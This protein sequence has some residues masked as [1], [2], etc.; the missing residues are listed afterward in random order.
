MQ[1][2]LPQTNEGTDDLAVAVGV[3]LLI[4]LSFWLWKRQ[5]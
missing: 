4:G 2:R 1:K 3:A 5:L